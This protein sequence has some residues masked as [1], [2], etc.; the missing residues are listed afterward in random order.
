[1]M[2]VP[3]SEVGRNGRLSLTFSSQC[4]RTLI[5]DVY[6]EVPFKITRVRN[7]EPLGIS[8]LI[9]M[10]C[11][12]G[13]FGGDIL[14]CT[15]HVERGARVLI[16]QQSSTKI[17]P[18]RE[19][20][21]IQRNQIRV[22]AGGEL[23][24]HA[25]PIIPFARSRLNQTTSI[26]VDHGGRL[27]FWESF[28]AG[29]IASGEVWQFEELASETRLRINGQ[30]VYLDRFRIAPKQ[31]SPTDEWMA[32]DALYVGSALCVDE[33]AADVGLQLH[34]MMPAA[35]VDTVTSEVTAVRLAVPDGPTFHTSRAIFS[36]LTLN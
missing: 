29:R 34:Q 21:A 31:Q 5:R 13:L 26:E 7:L 24:F 2:A 15:V 18:S 22:E 4:G 11:T 36:D 30:L 12:A 23:H 1:M 17:H 9:L 27:Y 33:R 20:C 3:L 14:E 6:S 19:R 32:G 28:M 16:T 35:G 25:E 10:H 8:H